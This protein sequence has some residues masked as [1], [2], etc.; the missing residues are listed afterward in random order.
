MPRSLLKTLKWG[1]GSKIFTYSVNQISHSSNYVY[2]VLITTAQ[3]NKR[4]Y[5]Y[6]NVVDDGPDNGT[7]A[8]KI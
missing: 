3:Y 2:F 4:G 8:E 1:F 7:K 6:R 5:Q